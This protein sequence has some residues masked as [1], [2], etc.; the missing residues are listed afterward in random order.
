M[1]TKDN[2]IYNGVFYVFCFFF[3]LE[4][5][6]NQTYITIN[7]M[8]LSFKPFIMESTVSWALISSVENVANKMIFKF[9]FVAL[10][11]R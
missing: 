3:S 11:K 6:K 2:K 4:K 8:P 1:K 5:N 9:D 10:R 7:S